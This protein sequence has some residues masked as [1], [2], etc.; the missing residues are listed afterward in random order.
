MK[1]IVSM[2]LCV[3]AAMVACADPVMAADEPVFSVSA[4]DVNRAEV[5]FSKPE[6]SPY[7][8]VYLTREKV[9]EFADFT[10]AHVGKQVSVVVLGEVVSRPRVMQPIKASY[11]EIRDKE[12]MDAV[13][14][15]WRLFKKTEETPNKE[16]E[17]TR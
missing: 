5:I 6:G 11:F 2:M 12:P 16:S 9:K 8:K 13:C 1:A 7:V 17:A 14:I 10:A 3:G 4:A 15:A